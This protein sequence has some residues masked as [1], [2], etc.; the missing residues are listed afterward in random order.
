MHLIVFLTV[1]GVSSVI[2]HYSNVPLIDKLDK[3]VTELKD[4]QSKMYG[5]MDQ[6]ETNIMKKLAVDDTFETRLSDIE[7]TVDA[8]KIYLT[9]EKRRDTELVKRSEKAIRQINHKV[10]EAR[11]LVANTKVDISKSVSDF[12]NRLV[13]VKKSAERNMEVEGVIR[14]GGVGTSCSAGNDACAVEKSECRHG[15]CQCEPGYSYNALTQECTTSCTSYGTT[16][17]S[18]ENRVI[19]GHNDKVLEG[20][21]FPECKKSCFDADGFVCRS[22]D[23]FASMKECYLSSVTALEAEDNWEYNSIGYHFQRDCHA[24]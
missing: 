2:G 23:Y 21:S 7:E 6:M 14:Y 18:I 20:V 19:R 16:F 3:D 8:L 5:H 13:S 17:Q 1:F 4:S 15:R 9:R 11:D 22:I 12:E 10:T 24:A